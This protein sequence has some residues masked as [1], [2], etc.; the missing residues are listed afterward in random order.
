MLKDRPQVAG[1]AIKAGLDESELPGFL[2]LLDKPAPWLEWV[3]E[4]Q[5]RPRAIKGS[6]VIPGQ[7]PVPLAACRIEAFS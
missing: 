5:I 1:A 7:K 2:A 6:L 3:K 4:V